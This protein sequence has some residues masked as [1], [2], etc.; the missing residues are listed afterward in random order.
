RFGSGDTPSSPAVSNRY[1]STSSTLSVISEPRRFPGEAPARQGL[2][3]SL[4]FKDQHHRGNLRSRQTG[5]SGQHVDP[6]G[7]VRKGVEQLEVVAIGLLRGGGGR[8]GGALGLDRDPGQR[9]DL[10]ENV[11]RRLD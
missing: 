11:V 2:H 4:E 9:P 7:V 1:I 6:C 5:P 10:G 8:R 3:C